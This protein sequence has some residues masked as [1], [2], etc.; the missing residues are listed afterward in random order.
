MITT[1][2]R[3]P[4][5]RILQAIEALLINFYNSDIE[6]YRDRDGSKNEDGV[7]AGLAILRK[8]KKKMVQP[9]LSLRFKHLHL[10]LNHQP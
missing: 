4:P 7:G 6:N 3:Q 10:L 9:N 8:N 1:E 5:A 2:D